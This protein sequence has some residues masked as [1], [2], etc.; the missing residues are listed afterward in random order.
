M[1]CPPKTA[2]AN[3]RRRRSEDRLLEVMSWPGPMIL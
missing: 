3:P 1:K 2:K